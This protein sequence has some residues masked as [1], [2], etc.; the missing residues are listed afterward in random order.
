MVQKV[1]VMSNCATAG[2]AHSMRML[3]Q[4]LDVRVCPLSTIKK[5]DTV[6]ENNKQFDVTFLHPT[7]IRN[8]PNIHQKVAAVSRKLIV[9]P[10]PYFD[11]YHPDLCYV[12]SNGNRI[13][14]P[15]GDYHSALCLAAFQA[16]LSVDDAISLFDDATYDRLGYYDIWTEARDLMLKGFANHGHDIGADFLR[17]T[18]NGP[19]LYSVNHP[20]IQCLFDLAKNF[21]VAADLSYISPPFPPADNLSKGPWFPVYPG[22][23]ERCGVESSMLFKLKQQDI[24]FNLKDFVTGSF[25]IYTTHKD[26]SLQNTF[27]SRPRFV[28]LSEFLGGTPA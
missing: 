16:G 26:V 8:F 22:I 20:R 6:I 4:S 3:N 13:D 18:K 14:S 7:V 27:A 2:L 19:F 15:I 28:A 12:T 21:F 10:T 25:A 1:L 11:G 5:I 9:T 17:W 24:F 23:A